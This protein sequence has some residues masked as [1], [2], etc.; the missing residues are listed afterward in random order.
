[1]GGIVDQVNSVVGS[2]NDWGQAY[3]AMAVRSM[4]LLVLVLV[5]AKLLGKFLKNILTKIGLPERRAIFMIT[6]LH[7]FLLI[8]MT[9]VVLNA[10]GISGILLM[11][12]AVIVLLTFIA[13]M[14]ILRPYIPKLPFKVGNAIQVAG[15]V[16]KVE[17][18]TFVHTAIKTFDGKTMFLP[19]HKLF[20]DLVINFHSTPTRR[21]DISFFIS[22]EEDLDKTKFVVGEILAN[23]ERILE[24]PA[25]KVVIK[26]FKPEYIE[27]QARVWVQ[28]KHVLV[29]RWDLQEEIKK[30]FDQEGIRMAPP[31]LEIRQVAWES[32]GPKA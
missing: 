18:I 7:V 3:G 32:A 31:R 17:A 26:E 12:A 8:A 19:N 11:R 27:M 15:N 21:V 9:T 28:N 6:A 1:M 30:R 14:V 10:L 22:Y 2:F 5:V 13:I 16:G 29:I 20:N 23:E 24:N 25:P 4:L